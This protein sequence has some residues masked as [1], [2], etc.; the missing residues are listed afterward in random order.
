M[1][2]T[3]NGP[4][5]WMIDTSHNL[6]DPMEDLLQSVETIK[7]AYAK[8]LLVD[9]EHLKSAQKQNDVVI[10]QSILQEVFRMDVRA[11][12]NESCLQEGGAIH[13]IEAYRT[14]K[15]RQK[16]IEAR[17]LDSKSTGL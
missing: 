13:P 4:L 15:I 2:E 6:K 11:L 5:S 3:A 12:V 10:C 16:L 17:G 8:A 14:F 9:Y 1:E 7:I